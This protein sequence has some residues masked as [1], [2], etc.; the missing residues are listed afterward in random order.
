MKFE[1]NY[2]NQR[3][4][5]D[6]EPVD[7]Q[8]DIIE[9]IKR[10]IPED[11]KTILDAGCGNGIISNPLTDKYDITALDISESALS[12]VKAEKKVLS[13][14]DKMPF[15]DN[16]F[17]L[18]MTNDLLEHLDD[19]TYNSAISEILRVSKK[20]VII[21]SPFLEN[22]IFNTTKCKSCGKEFH[23][24]IHKRSFKL[25]K[26]GSILPG[27][28]LKK[29]VFCG[30][31]YQSTLSPFIRIR[32]EKGYY[33]KSG[34][35]ICP[36]CGERQGIDNDTEYGGYNRLIDAVEI[37]YLLKNRQLWERRPEVLEF[38]GLYEKGGER[39][40]I[41]IDAGNIDVTH[42]LSSNKLIFIDAL[43]K[44]EIK[45]FYPY[46]QYEVLLKDCE[47][48]DNGLRIKSDVFSDAIKFSFP[49]INKRDTKFEI[50]FISFSDSELKIS[51]YNPIINGYEPLDKLIV[52]KGEYKKSIDLFDL[53]FPSRYGLLFKLEMR[54][55]LN[56]KKMELVSVDNISDFDVIRTDGYIN[57]S[58]SGIEYRI[59]CSGELIRP[60]WFFEDFFEYD[61]L[62]I[63]E[64]NSPYDEI[65]DHIP[66]MFERLSSS[67]R[68][69][70]K[71]IMRLKTDLEQKEVNRSKAEESYKEALS[72]IKVLNER[73]EEKEKERAKAEEVAERYLNDIKALEVRNN[74]LNELINEIEVK[75]GKA[76][77][78]YK[79]A[80]S[81]IKVLNERL[82]QVEEMRQQT[83]EVA[84]KYLSEIGLLNQ[85]I[86][87]LSK[88]SNEIEIKR[89]YAEQKYQELLGES[90][91]I[92][93]EYEK[94]IVENK[95]LKE[96]LDK[97]VQKVREMEDTLKDL[98]RKKRDLEIEKSDLKRSFE[99]IR[100][101]K[102][103]RLLV[104]SHMFPHPDQPVFGPFVL[105]Q[106]KALLKYTDLDIRVISCR[107][108]WMNT[109]NPLKLKEANRIYWE[110][111]KEVR[112]E[113]RDGVK[114]MYPP[115]RVGGPFR[116]IT[117]WHT[118]SQAVLSVI[119]DVL[120]DFRFDMIHAHT[121]YIDGNAARLIY[122]KFKT[123]YIITEH[124]GPYSEYVRNP[125]VL[126]KS[127]EASRYA[128]RVLC[129][130]PKFRDE[131]ASFMPQDIKP[132]LLVNGNGVDTDKFYPVSGK[133]CKR[134]PIRLSMVGSLESIKN[135]ILMLKVFK[136]LR[137]LRED[138]ILNVVGK[139]DLYDRMVEF[140][141]TN[142]LKDYVI[143]YNYMYG[144][145][146]SKFLRESIDILVHP[147]RSESFGVVIIEA[148]S[149]GKPVIATRCGGPEYIINDDR[150][151]R[152]V[153]VDDEEEFFDAVVDVINNYESY[154][155]LWMHNNIKD[156]F[157]FESFA[158]KLRELYE[159]VL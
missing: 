62:K 32:Q 73:L 99:I 138:V 35:S 120:K 52:L 44:R 148:L 147:S 144:D 33:I 143:F 137:N 139:G 2:Y 6:R 55:D 79:E 155:P 56:I 133:N 7:Y 123:P 106:V 78:S 24:N 39:N 77:E 103:R 113:E 13:S 124:M 90:N 16:S 74:E 117:H 100:G 125:I 91:Q 40:N 41:D 15:E 159:E 146:Y 94:F 71:G 51:L 81:E 53:A 156:R 116:F 102:I 115:Y 128:L 67:H 111:I 119:F 11:V 36:F 122:E 85:R 34:D 153:D 17:D 23:I 126:N 19:E 145:E 89:N 80:L 70:E 72:E 65:K 29:V 60:L 58:S 82:N 45:P 130:S 131:I 136:R 14:V 9:E 18:V 54:G 110:K 134:Y 69:I 38:I 4:I 64:I 93:K 114:V 157:G 152:L 26:I 8:K 92:K 84:S 10:L 49:H 83:E 129:V 97:E 3:S 101:R 68:I 154:D 75:R 132:K 95:E 109:Y 21:T 25:D 88:L 57:K 112:W 1:L 42:R 135:P 22:L 47:S 140:V 98:E 158:K 151:G 118:Y 149:C 30:D 20:Y 76:E 66:E 127:I 48:I 108:F 87:E 37:V 59:K 96:Q 61:F 86:N 43:S 5:W 46:P 27:A 142:N 150:L 50:E 63:I 104:L 107:P 28:S 105:D 141:E 31:I 121:A 12:F